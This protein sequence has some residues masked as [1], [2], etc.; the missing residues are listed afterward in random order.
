M[1]VDEIQPRLILG[2]TLFTPDGTTAPAV[3]VDPTVLALTTWA[4]TVGS[5]LPIVPS[6]LNVDPAVVS[7]PFIR[8]LVDSTDLII[9]FTLAGILLKT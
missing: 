2:R 4:A 9:H 5:I 7:A 8:S 6:K 1:A 3:P